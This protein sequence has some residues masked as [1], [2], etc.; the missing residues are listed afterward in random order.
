MGF[1]HRPHDP[2][3]LEGSSGNPPRSLPGDPRSSSMHRTACFLWIFSLGRSMRN[4]L[5]SARQTD[6]DR[7]EKALELTV[8]CGDIMRGIFAHEKAAEYYRIVIEQTK[9]A[10]ELR[11]TWLE[12]HEKLGNIGIVSGDTLRGPRFIRL[13]CCV[14]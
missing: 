8:R 9:N 11:N 7:V 14:S 5:S 1:A 13:L 6:S 2:M 3:A 4:V 12:T 10:P